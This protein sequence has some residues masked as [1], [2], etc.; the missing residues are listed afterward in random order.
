M[1]HVKTW[2]DKAY[3]RSYSLRQNAQHMNQY[4]LEDELNTIKSFVQNIMDSTA[5]NEGDISQYSSTLNAIAENLEK[6]E[7][8]LERKKK[9]FFKRLI[10]GILNILGTVLGIGPWGTKLLESGTD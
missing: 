10:A 9:P 3:S 6:V 8:V 1:T 7:Q 2:I 4:E 5:F